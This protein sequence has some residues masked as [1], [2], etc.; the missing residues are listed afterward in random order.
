VN[1]GVALRGYRLYLT[2]RCGA[3]PVPHSDRRGGNGK[4]L[5]EFLTLSLDMPNMQA[6]AFLSEAGSGESDPSC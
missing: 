4:I 1:Y 2:S 3:V 6:L 5:I